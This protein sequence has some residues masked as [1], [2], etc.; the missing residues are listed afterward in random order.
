M[1]AKQVLISAAIVMALTELL[2]GRG[3]GHQTV[4]RTS[5]DQPP[6]R[7]AMKSVP[8]VNGEVRIPREPQRIVALGYLGYLLTLDLKP[9]GATSDELRYTFLKDKIAGIADM[10]GYPY[11]LE[12]ILALD[13]DLIIIMDGQ[14]YQQLSRIAPTI[15]I[16]WTS[17]DTYEQLRSLA[18][19]LD[20]SAAAK[21]WIRRFEAQGRQAREKL[22]GVLGEDETVGVY[23][24]WAKAFW[25]VNRYYGRGTRNLYQTLGLKPPAG[26]EQYV[27]GKKSGLNMSLELLPRYAADHMFISVYAAEGDAKRVQEI[28][29]SAIWRNLPAVKK[30]RVYEL[31]FEQFFS[32]DPLSL[33]K[34]LALQVEMLVSRNKK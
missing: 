15:V 5:Q 23:E 17:P 30:G 34:Q 29:N 6:S 8:T 14:N 32:A 27:L 13:P 3:N 25:V 22:A 28:M 18:E 21:A 4:A 12:K 2:A 33:E 31:N 20:R 26:I 7:V 16:P 24:I 11:S 9:V 10:G 1:R 19:M